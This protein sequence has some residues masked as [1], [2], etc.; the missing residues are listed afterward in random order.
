MMPGPHQT[1][2]AA[3]AGQSAVPPSHALVTRHRPPR[4]GSSADSRR[5]STDARHAPTL[6]A[7]DYLYLKAYLERISGNFDI[8]FRKDESGNVTGL[9][10]RWIFGYCLPD[11]E[12]PLGKVR[13]PEEYVGVPSVINRQI[14]EGALN[15]SQ[16]ERASILIYCAIVSGLY[17]FVVHP[18]FFSSHSASEDST[19]KTVFNILSVAAVLALVAAAGYYWSKLGSHRSIILSTAE[20]LEIRARHPEYF[21]PASVES[22]IKGR[23]D[24]HLAEL[25]IGKEQLKAAA[26]VEGPVN[27]ISALGATPATAGAAATAAGAGGAAAPARTTP[28]KGSAP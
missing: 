9:E 26:G 22:W 20:I 12:S 1:P 27:T 10:I 8:R 17:R 15:D 2:A 6:Q 4:R 28:M 19:G 11:R 5:T 18:L 3:A 24:A 14:R 16:A 7:L 13:T 23:L 21:T 25:G